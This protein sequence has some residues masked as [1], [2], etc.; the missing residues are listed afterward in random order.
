M[1]AVAIP[2]LSTPEVQSPNY[3]NRGLAGYLRG[4][5][6]SRGDRLQSRA[7]IVQEGRLPLL[8][9]FTASLSRLIPFA[10]DVETKDFISRVFRQK[11]C[12]GVPDSIHVKPSIDT[13]NG[14]LMTGAI[15]AGTV[16]CCG[17][18]NKAPSVYVRVIRG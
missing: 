10:S 13:I 17:V 11:L 6:P 4:L 18:S 16:K 9:Y 5:K 7:Y 12:K 8:R 3:V 14:F 2:L 1:A 15:S